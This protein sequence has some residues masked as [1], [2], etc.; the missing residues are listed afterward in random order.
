[1]FQS[2]VH[3]KS[4]LIL[5]NPLD[6]SLP[7]SSVHEILWVRIS[8]VGCHFLTP[9]DLPDLEMEHVSL[10]SHASAGEF[11]TTNATWEA[12]HHFKVNQFGGN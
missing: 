12:L 6:C 4:C 3:A 10:M 8:G 11:F 1:M 5:S 7:G 2:C 9:E